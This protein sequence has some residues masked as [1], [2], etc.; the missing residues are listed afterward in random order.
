MLGIKTRGHTFSDHRIL[1]GKTDKDTAQSG[2]G[3]SAQFIGVREIFVLWN[4][5]HQLF[6]QYRRITDRR[7]PEVVP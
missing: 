5:A 2:R 1:D 3:L 4:L 7:L 6:G